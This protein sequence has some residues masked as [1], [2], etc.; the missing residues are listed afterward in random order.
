MTFIK[1]LLF[2]YIQRYRKNTIN[3]L[4]DN[5]NSLS[6]IYNKNN[7]NTIFVSEGYD[8]RYPKN[9]KKLEIERQHI[10]NLHNKKKLLD[11]LEDKNISITVKQELLQDNSIKTPNLMAGNLFKVFDSDF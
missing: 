3:I 1:T 8:E 5:S 4:I 2:L 6:T 9:E 11:I 7:N 10:Y